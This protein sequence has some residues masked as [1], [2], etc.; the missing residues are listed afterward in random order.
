MRPTC[1]FPFSENILQLSA[2]IYLGLLFGVVPFSFF[3]FFEKYDSAAVRAFL[4]VFSIFVYSAITTTAAETRTSFARKPPSLGRTAVG[5]L[6]WRD[7]GGFDPWACPLLPFVCYTELGFCASPPVVRRQQVLFPMPPRE[8]GGE[9]FNSSKQDFLK[10]R[11]KG[12]R[13]CLMAPKVLHGFCR[14][15]VYEA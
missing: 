1:N 3:L 6:W 8:R 7:R 2:L 5:G 9:R 4:T 13:A 10:R 14:R 15:I 11:K 12:R